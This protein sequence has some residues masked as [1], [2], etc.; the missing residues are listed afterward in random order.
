LVYN[1]ALYDHNSRLEDGPDML[2]IAEMDNLEAALIEAVI[3]E[4]ESKETLHGLLLALGMLLYQAGLDS[5]IWELCR[6]MD[7]REALQQKGKMSIFAEEPLLQEVGEE[8][9]GKGG[10]L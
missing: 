3:N 5:S 8:L 9:L 10:K 1:M 4:S 7:V 2:K 6:A